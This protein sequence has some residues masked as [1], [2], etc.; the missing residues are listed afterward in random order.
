M[1]LASRTDSYYSANQFM[2]YGQV[3]VWKAP[4]IYR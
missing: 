2:S 4:L 3:L 1:L